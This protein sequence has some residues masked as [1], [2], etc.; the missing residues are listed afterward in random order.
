MGDLVENDNISK[1]HKLMMLNRKSMEITGVEDV[2]S[3]DTKEVLLETTMG[4]LT[5]KGE[6]LKVNRLSIEKGELEI[7]RTVDSMEYSEISSYKRKK[8]KMMDSLFR[9]YYKYYFGV[10][11]MD[12][13]DKLERMCSE[14]ES[15]KLKDI[16][17][18]YIEA[19]EEYGGIYIDE[20]INSLVESLYSVKMGE[21]FK[22]VPDSEKTG[23]PLY[24]YR[25]E[26]LRS[27]GGPD[28]G[29]ASGK[30]V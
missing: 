1:A 26:Y 10:K 9:L 21:L 28:N 12:N 5:I 17:L 30:A 4:I 6:D 7:E 23:L 15:E 13:I 25:G 2:I 19:M 8:E 16:F 18:P 27:I 3:F 22:N 20:R 29:C 14:G 24:N 11:L